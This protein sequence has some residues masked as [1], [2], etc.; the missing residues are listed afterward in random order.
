MKIITLEEHFWD[1]DIRR[2]LGGGGLEAPLPQ[3]TSYIAP[4]EVEEDIDAGRIADMDKSSITMQVLSGLGGQMLTGADAVPLAQAANNRLAAAT[5]K[6]PDRFA[7]FA[8]L[9]TAE[10]QAAA[11][12]L[13]RCVEELGFVGTTIFGRTKGKF[14]DAPEYDVILNAA[15]D[16]AVPIY[17]HPAYPPREVRAAN[18]DG[19]DPA[20]SGRFASAAWGWHQETAVHLLHMI[21]S[22]VFDRH[23]RL[24]IIAGHWG[25]M[26][27]FYLDRLGE[28]LPRTLTRLERTVGEYM[29]ENVYITPSGMFSQPQLEF[30]I[31]VLGIE[32]ILF[33]VDYPFIGN[34]GAVPF[35]E[36]AD[37]T[38]RERAMIAHEN[39]IK[40]L[41]LNKQVML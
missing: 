9:P 39:T 11:E 8:C 37:L 34:E 10:P 14:L 33:S 23:P 38:D 22:G 16:L 19:L 25:E 4:P 5:A 36:Q 27:P 3:G 1:P 29:R 41:K 7:G 30:C 32:R 6:Y 28:A 17:L 18:Y 31:K 12:E 35:L 26:I 40:L 13:R 20:V 2:T 21:L 24:Q 15:E